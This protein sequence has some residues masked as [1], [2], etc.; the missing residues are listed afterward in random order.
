MPLRVAR[1]YKIKQPL[2]LEGMPVAQICLDKFM[3]R[4]AAADMCCRDAH[5]NVSRR[6]Q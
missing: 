6:E 3:E 4:L 1:M 2:R 5:I